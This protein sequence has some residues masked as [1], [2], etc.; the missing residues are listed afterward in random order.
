MLGDKLMHWHIFVGLHSFLVLFYKGRTTFPS[1][2]LLVTLHKFQS[3]K[4]EWET[5]DM[6]VAHWDAN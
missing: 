4:S 2:M 5:D 1:L 3:P 6:L